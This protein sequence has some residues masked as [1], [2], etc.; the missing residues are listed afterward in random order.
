MRKNIFITICAALILILAAS[1]KRCDNCLHGGSCDGNGGC[2]CVDPW[3]GRNCDTSCTLGYEGYNCA[4]LSRERFITA[5]WDC[6]STDP[7]GNKST[8][9]ITFTAN[10]AQPVEMY[11]TNFNDK[12]Y[13]LRCVLTGKKEFDIPQ[14]VSTNGLHA[15]V[16]G[17]AILRGSTLTLY[18]TEDGTS[19]FATAKLQ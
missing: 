11:L 8:Y 18:I 5:S 7:L 2:A 15:S 9:P 4:T 1:C 13:R 12:G 3:S 17:N 10:P 14:Q 19:Y 16:I 6:T